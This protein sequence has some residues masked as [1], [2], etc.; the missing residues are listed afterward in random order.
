MKPYDS[1]IHTHNN[2]IGFLYRYF[3]KIQFTKGCVVHLTQ[4]HFPI[5]RNVHNINKNSNCN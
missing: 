1:T 4:A 3:M 2:C 5:L